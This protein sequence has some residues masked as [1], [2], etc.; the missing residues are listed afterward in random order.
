MDA[1]SEVLPDPTEFWY[2]ATPGQ[3]DCEAPGERPSLTGWLAVNAQYIPPD[4]RF[5]CG[6]SPK[7]FGGQRDQGLMLEQLAS[8]ELQDFPERAGQVVEFLY[9]GGR[10]GDSLYCFLGRVDEVCFALV[11]LT[12]EGRD[13]AGGW[14]VVEVDGEVD[15]TVSLE[16]LHD[17]V[18][19]GADPVLGHRKRHHRRAGRK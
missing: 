2:P 17:A 5:V 12:G 15:V 10:F 4:L 14:P 3:P 18:D 9:I 1:S 16:D 8:A 13:E 6:Q 7:V 19:R 11:C